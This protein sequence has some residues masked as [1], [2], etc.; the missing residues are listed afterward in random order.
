MLSKDISNFEGYSGGLAWLLE[1]QLVNNPE[2]L[3][4]IVL[5][6]HKISW[7]IKTVELLMDYENFKMLIYV[8]LNW[9]GRK[10]KASKIEKQVY[11]ML[12]QVLPSYGIRVIYDKD[13]FE[14]A[15]SITKKIKGYSNE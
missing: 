12:K 9:Y 10:F 6:L 1:M 13:L 5:N 14:K 11:F 4:A 2:V 3:N 7:T 8:D 15:V